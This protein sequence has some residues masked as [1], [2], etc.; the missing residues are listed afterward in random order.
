MP[1]TIAQWRATLK[2]K[3][4]PASRLAVNFVRVAKNLE[5]DISCQTQQV[6]LDIRQTRTD[7]PED[8]TLSHTK[9]CASCDE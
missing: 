8:F 7:I 9:I 5:R 6:S 1:D 4:D 2:Y 3:E